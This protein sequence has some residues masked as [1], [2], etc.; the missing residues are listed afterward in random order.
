MSVAERLTVIE[1]ATGWFAAPLSHADKT[2]DNATSAAT[3]KNI[4]GT[5]TLEATTRA[6]TGRK[7]IYLSQQPGSF[8]KPKVAGQKTLW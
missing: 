2:T 8:A 1:I 7:G 5:Y 6:T 4:N 3:R